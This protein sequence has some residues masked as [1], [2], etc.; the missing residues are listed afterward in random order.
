MN[1]PPA[2]KVV[3]PLT[4]RHIQEHGALHH[5]LLKSGAMKVVVSEQPAPKVNTDL[6]V[7]D[8]E[9]IK[10]NI[11]S[12]DD[13]SFSTFES[14]LKDLIIDEFHHQYE[15]KHVTFDLDDDAEEK[16]YYT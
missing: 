8:L 16:E 1:T 12:A 7:K 5:R 2:G 15:K 14:K 6:S 11:N 9:T 13:E 4:G 3:N 10:D